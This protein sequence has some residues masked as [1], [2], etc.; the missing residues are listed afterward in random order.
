VYS[1]SRVGIC[2]CGGNPIWDTQHGKDHILKPGNLLGLN[3]EEKICT[4]PNAL[5]TTSRCAFG[6]EETQICHSALNDEFDILQL[7][8]L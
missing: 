3:S 8:F 2:S 6:F 7:H 5:M 4:M 1:C